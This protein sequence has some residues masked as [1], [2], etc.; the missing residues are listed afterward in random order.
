M[1]VGWA[2]ISPQVDF[3]CVRKKCWVVFLASISVCLSTLLIIIEFARKVDC[4]APNVVFDACLI[5][6][7]WAVVLHVIGIVSRITHVNVV[8]SHDLLFLHKNS[9]VKLAVDNLPLGRWQK[10]LLRRNTHVTS[11]LSCFQSSHRRPTS[12]KC[13]F[14]DH[15]A[16]Y[17]APPLSW[18]ALLS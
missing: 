14:A 15:F 1:I 8:S 13:I 16:V 7:H 3:I 9:R 12:M 17:D 6:H 10:S 5:K 2:K 18:T 11:Y 4:T